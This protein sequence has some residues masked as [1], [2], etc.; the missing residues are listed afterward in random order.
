MPEPAI[1]DLDHL[2]LT[3]TD[4]AATTAFYT[5]LGMTAVSRNGRHE[6]RFGSRKINLHLAPGEFQPAADRPV[7]GSADLCFTV[8][9]TMDDLQRHLRQ[10]NLAVELGPVPREGARGPMRSVYLRDPDGNLVELAV[11]L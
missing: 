2:V 1:A 6:L 3:I 9:A 4:L 8:T 11:Y 7:P 5:A 10:H